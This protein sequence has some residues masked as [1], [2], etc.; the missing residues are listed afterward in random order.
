VGKLLATKAAPQMKRVS[1]EL[2]GHAPFLVFEDAD[3][4]HAAKGAAA[5]K[6]LNTGQACICP[7]RLLVHRSIAD[8]FVATLKERFAALKAGNGLTDGVTVGPL[9]DAEAGAKME[10]QVADAVAKGATLVHGGQRLTEGGLDK[11]WF[12]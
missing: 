11:G 2:G 9:I 1:M 5:V 6:F 12:F 3:P 7:N 8:R 4:V 10:R